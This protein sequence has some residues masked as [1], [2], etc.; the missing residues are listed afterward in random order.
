MV[1]MV[2]AI[3]VVCLP[4]LKSLLR[5]GEPSTSKRGI[6]ANTNTSRSK[7]YN[8][9]GHGPGT[10]HIKLSSGRDTY[11]SG[12]RATTVE[13][14][15]SEVELHNMRRGDV[16]YKTQRLSITSVRREDMA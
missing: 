5:R 14:S 10:S 16:I 9:Y 8:A 1:E 11:V 2:A 15:G 3:V 13:E 6:S 7:T 12:T 4:A